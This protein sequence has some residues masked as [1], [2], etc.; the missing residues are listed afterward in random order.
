M[1][2]GFSGDYLLKVFCSNHLASFEHKRSLSDVRHFKQDHV[3]GMRPWDWVNLETLPLHAAQLA[4]WW[5][6]GWL[7]RC[8]GQ[9]KRATRSCVWEGGWIEWITGRWTAQIVAR[10]FGPWRWG[11]KKFCL[12]TSFR[13]GCLFGWFTKHSSHFLVCFCCVT[14]WNCAFR[15]L[16]RCNRFAKSLFAVFSAT[17]RPNL[18]AHFD[19]RNVFGNG[20]LIF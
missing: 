3:R 1:T 5:L 9:L 20:C 10:L 2:S 11:H 15:L 12:L 8:R 17:P 19:W 6:E 16:Q 7:N 4:K 13:S 14:R 18:F